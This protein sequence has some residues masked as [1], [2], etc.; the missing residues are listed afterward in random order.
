MIQR[1]FFACLP[2]SLTIL[3][4]AAPPARAGDTCIPPAVP[5]AL[6][7][8]S[9]ITR[10]PPPAKHTPTVAPPVAPPKKSPDAAPAKPDPRVGALEIRRGLASVRSTELLV[11][12]IQGLETLFGATSARS[13]DRAGILRRLAD[14]Y[15]ELETSSFRKKLESRMSAD[16]ARRKDPGKVAALLAEAAKAEKMEAAARQNAIRYYAQLKS[17]HPGFCQS[18]G[19]GTSAAK[20]SGCV[21]EILYNLAYEHEQAGDLDQARKDYLELI[22]TS[23]ASKYVPN[24]YLAFGELFFQEAQGDPSKWALA[25]QSYKEVTKYPAPDN[26][27]LGYARYKLAYVYWN[28]GDLA[29]AMSEMKKTI[30]LGVQFP[31]L[32]NADQLAV[33]ARRDI[34]PLYA[35]AGDPKK[36]YDLFHPLSGDGTSDNTRT[37]RMMGE[38]GQGYLDVGRY[39]DAI[40]LYQDLLRRDRGPKSCGYQAHVTEATLAWKTG[41]K[42]ASKAE[43]DRQLQVEQAFR[44]EAYPDDAK[45]ACANATA[46]LVTETAMFWHLEAAGGVGSGGVRGTASPQTMTFADDLYQKVIKQFSAAQFARFEFPRIVKE[47]WPTLLKVKSARADLLYFQKEWA[48]CGAAFDEVVAEDPHG[49]LAAESAYASALCNQNAYLAAHAGRSDRVGGAAASSVAP[50]ELGAGEKA[51]L[52]SFDRYLCVATPDPANRAAYDTYVEIEYARARTYFEAH[53]WPEAAAGFRAVALTRSDHES[54]IFAAQLYLEALNVM[55][56]HGTPGCFDDMS[57]DLPA[58]VDAFCAGAKG[59]TNAEQCGM[60]ARIQRDVDW[61]KADGIVEAIGKTPADDQAKRWEEAA[62]GYLRVWQS[63]GKD[64]CEAKQPACERMDQVLFNAARAFQ[65]ARLLAKAIAV[66][67]L[68]IDPRYNLDRTATARK[69]VYDIGANY[70]AIAVY[71]E[72]AS[73]YERFAHDS[74]ADD[75]APVALEDAIVLRLGL[76]QEDLAVRDADAFDRDQRGKHAATAAQ[77][78]FAIGAHHVEQEDYAQAKRRLGNA[79][80]EID[81]SAAVDVQIQAHAMLGRAL[82]KMGGETGAAAEYAKVRALFRDPAAVTARLASAEAD[83][84]SRTRRLGKLLTAVGEAI[85]FSAEQKRKVADRLQFP[86]YKGSG[87]REDVL[88]HIH[89]RVAEWVKKKHPAIEEAEKEY[90]RVLDIQPSPPPRWVIASGARV[91][92][93]WGKFVAEF[94]AAPIPREW[95]QTGPSPYGDLTWEEIRLAYVG[96]IDDASEPFRQR[97]K[98]AYEACLSYS[99]RYQ[100][101]DEHSRSC[102]LWLSRNYATEHHAVDE[103]RGTPSY[104]GMRIEGQPVMLAP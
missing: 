25:E 65:A 47:D 46:A 104:I 96:G 75:R 35:L 49:P 80:A 66:R 88:A 20:P 102:E 73:W 54:A 99:S 78:A 95:M 70:Q 12:E 101:F 94:R 59:K 2:V 61:K 30:E 56:S 18:P 16:E 53:R 11:V 1:L 42:A 72:A 51:M 82:W 38:L 77:I 103:L 6:A 8:C 39:H 14:G 58:L 67:K 7:A 5:A 74:P 43:L 4:A 23:P 57:R 40:D 69:T 19:G 60:L 100:Y 64:A 33:S 10:G 24:A 22:Q 21:D 29:L 17:Q 48:R 45:L 97:A 81:R 9:G 79:M 98:G 71:D 13:P 28:K 3:A 93:M 68:L 44:A 86:V 90:R 91:G 15:V 36:A 26:K 76:G 52:A 85:Y 32:P 37:F 87:R 34:V 83:E 50:R 27:A 31:R 41:D 89:T 62:N 63:Y 55:G 92:Q 84:A